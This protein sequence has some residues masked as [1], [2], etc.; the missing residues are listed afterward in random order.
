MWF[1][2]VLGRDCHQT[3]QAAEGL[4]QMHGH[5]ESRAVG[6]DIHLACSL[7]LHF[8]YVNLVFEH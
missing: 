4:E 3:S 1:E 2:F 8:I 5:G 6:N 7:K